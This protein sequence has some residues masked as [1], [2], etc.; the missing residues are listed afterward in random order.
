MTKMANVRNRGRGPCAACALTMHYR[1]EYD[2]HAL[3]GGCL[4]DLVEEG[5]LMFLDNETHEMITLE[6]E[7]P[8][9][10]VA[11]GST[12]ASAPN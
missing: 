4:A 5:Y 3:C 6:R 11:A 12:G 8:A 10:A 2:G 9:A 7:M 1:L